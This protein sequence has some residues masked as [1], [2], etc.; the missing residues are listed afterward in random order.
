M[1]FTTVQIVAMDL[2]RQSLNIDQSGT[3][4]I[5][6][7]GSSQFDVTQ[8]QLNSLSFAGVSIGV[9]NQTTSDANHDGYKDLKLQFQTSDALK[10][11]LTAIY[12]DLL[13]ADYAADHTYSTKQDALLAL[14]GTFGALGQQFEGT[15]STAVFLAGNSLK[16]LL[17]SLGI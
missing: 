7:Y 16:T 12:S 1:D 4:S 8:V 6:V 10:A 14:D 2:Q 3:I 15:D 17:S 9:F 13:L 11:A 5:V